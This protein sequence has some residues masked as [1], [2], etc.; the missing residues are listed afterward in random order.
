MSMMGV[1]ISPTS[2]SD[3]LTLLNAML[4]P[5]KAKQV[6]EELG[7]QIA[8]FQKLRDEAH[9][10]QK[11]AADERAAA[12]EALAKVTSRA[13]K[14]EELREANER[15]TAE[16][17]VREQAVAG[18]EAAIGKWKEECEATLTGRES[19]VKH[20]EQAL[21]AAEADHKAKAE[22]LAALQEDLTQRMAKLKQLI[23]D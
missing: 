18:Q 16:L 9:A 14:A 13:E 3:A 11:A 4:E 15:K 12:D 6:M 2:V 21:K 1:S 20:R 17:S 7:K 8:E 22:E 5:K 23:G 10:M 19:S